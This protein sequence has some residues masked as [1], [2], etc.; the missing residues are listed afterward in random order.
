MCLC[1]QPSWNARIYAWIARAFGINA[2]LLVLDILLSP[3][4]SDI[5]LLIVTFTDV[6]FRVS[7]TSTICIY[8]LHGNLSYPNWKTQLQTSLE[9]NNNKKLGIPCH[10]CGNIVRIQVEISGKSLPH[11]LSRLTQY[12]VC[13]CA[14]ARTCVVNEKMTTFSIWLQNKMVC[15]P[16]AWAEMMWTK[17]RCLHNFRWVNVRYVCHI[18]RHF[19]YVS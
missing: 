11:T 14:R 15:V 10:A 12:C 8:I 18:K 9:H 19:I 2:K 4:A 3:Y 7:N 16:F 5:I 6:F 1:V 17:L 13:E